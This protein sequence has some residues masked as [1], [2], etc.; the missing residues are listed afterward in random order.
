[1]S[2]VTAQKVITDYI[3]KSLQ[4]SNVNSKE[5]VAPWHKAGF[6]VFAKNALTGKFYRGVNVWVLGITAQS[7]GYPEN[8]WG[9]Y[10]QLQQ[11]GLQV[12]KHET[13]TPVIFFRTIEKHDANGDVESSIPLWR[14]STVFNVAQ[15]EGYVAPAV[16]SS[17]RFVDL[18]SV[19]K[20]IADTG[21]DIRHGGS[22]A[23]YSPSTDHIQLPLKES[24]KTDAHASNVEHYYSVAFHEL[25]HWTKHKS[26]LDRN[27]NELNT[28]RY[29]FE[30]L[31]A[32]L[33]AAFL[34]ASFGLPS[35]G[36]TDHAQYIKGWLEALQN[37]DKFIVQAASKAQAAVDFLQGF[38]A[39]VEAEEAA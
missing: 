31:V 9:S 20:F 26:R 32:E 1:M 38:Q 15:T 39:S 25:V 10:K 19:E 29:A 34:N 2:K 13:G 36:R 21:A 35:E 24:F 11:K 33:G 12:R 14:Y 16:G 27:N 37:D 23:F 30:E 4:D 6:N 8:V 5:W 22:S 18:E 17:E 7:R 3:L 28:G